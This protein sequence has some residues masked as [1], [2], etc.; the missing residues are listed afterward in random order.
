MN[1]NP[2]Y[3]FPSFNMVYSRTLSDAEIKSLSDNPWQIFSEHKRPKAPS[4]FLKFLKRFMIGLLVCILIA[5]A[6]YL[7]LKHE[8]T[9]LFQQKLHAESSQVLPNVLPNTVLDTTKK[10]IA[11]EGNL[12]SDTARQYASW[13][14]EYG[15]KYAV[16]PILIL[17]VVSVESRFDY[18]ANSGGAIGLMQIIPAYHKDKTSPPELFD[19]KKNI[20]VGTQILKE[21]SDSSRSTVETLLRYNGSLGAAP[22]YALKVLKAKLKFES[23]IFSAIRKA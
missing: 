4:N 6:F 9:I 13:I 3:T 14:F 22:S 10:I 12:D 17:S 5:S 2:T 18:K 8:Q 1:T 15:A 21:Y 11:R 20:Q 19:P 16:D 23:E 7:N